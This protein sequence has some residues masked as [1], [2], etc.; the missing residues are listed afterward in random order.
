MEDITCL[1]VPRV[2]FH[3]GTLKYCTAGGTMCRDFVSSLYY[4]P[5]MPTFVVLTCMSHSTLLLL[6]APLCLPTELSPISLLVWTNALDC[7]RPY[8]LC[9]YDRFLEP[10]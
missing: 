8:W 5:M 1:V 3:N 6:S 2:M 9:G 7:P 10:S 4:T